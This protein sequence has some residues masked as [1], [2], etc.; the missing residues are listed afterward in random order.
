M[1]SF[2]I[3][4]VSDFNQ[5]QAMENEPEGQTG[6]S[7]QTHRTGKSGENQN[8]LSEFQVFVSVKI[9]RDDKKQYIKSSNDW[10][11]AM[12]AARFGQKSIL[13]YFLEVV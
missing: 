13:K 7:F 8:L 1:N 6:L 3:K 10:T 4:A 12:F 2:R 11:P 9:T 5:R